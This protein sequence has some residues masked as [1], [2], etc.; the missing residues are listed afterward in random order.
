MRDFLGTGWAFPVRVDAH[1]RIALAHQERD[2]E[3]AMRIILLT[4]KGQRVMR[5]EFGCQ[6]H[7]LIFAPNDATTAGL[8]AHYVEDA[9]NMWEPRIRVL[10]VAAQP[11]PNDGGRLLITVRYEIKAT[12]DQR[13]LVFPFY[14]IPGEPEHPLLA[15]RREENR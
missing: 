5:P 12:H 6:V 8:A 2:I 4:P 7:E 1:G 9:L 15:A 14:R 13:S 11:D 10:E 3:E